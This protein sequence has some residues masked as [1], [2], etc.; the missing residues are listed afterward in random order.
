MKL[1]I[2]SLNNA[3]GIYPKEL[4]IMASQKFA[5]S[6]CCCCLV[7][8]SCPALVTRYGLQPA[9]L[10]CPWDSP[11]K[12]TGVGCHFL[13]QGIFQT[14]G[15]NPHLLQWQVDSSP[16][17]HQGSLHTVFT[18][19]LFIIA[20]TWKQ[21]RCPQINKLVNSDKEISISAKKK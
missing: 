10:L 5:H 11:G 15:A 21:P 14:Q 13:L 17:S 4:K 2:R 1:N 20:R 8:K 16:L 6:V 9:R 3:F 19:A 7:I 18:A 12:Y